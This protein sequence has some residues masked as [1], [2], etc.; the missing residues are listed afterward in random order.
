MQ[1]TVDEAVAVLNEGQHPA[2]VTR[3]PCL[4]IKRI[5]HDT[6]ACA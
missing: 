5:K 3:R 4:L 1:K 6:S 2:I